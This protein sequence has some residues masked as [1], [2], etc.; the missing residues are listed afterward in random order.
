MDTTDREG[1]KASAA[2]EMTWNLPNVTVQGRRPRKFGRRARA[3]TPLV[4]YLLRS[5]GV[6]GRDA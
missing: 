1:G 2:T 6:S 4:A 3:S 5:G